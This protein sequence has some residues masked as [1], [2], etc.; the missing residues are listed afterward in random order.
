MNRLLLFCA[1]LALLALLA[2]CHGVT[3][4]LPVRG[5]SRI[6]GT[7][8]FQRTDAP[9]RFGVVLAFSGQDSV[10]FAVCD[11]LGRYAMT[12]RATTDSLTLTAWPD[13]HR[14]YATICTGFVHVAR[15]SA[16]VQDIVLDHCS[17]I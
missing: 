2:A 9:A 7:V 14:A 12:V 4:P 8:T 5:S 16:I 13:P 15:R 6:S 1:A 11:S 10:G 17:P 3:T